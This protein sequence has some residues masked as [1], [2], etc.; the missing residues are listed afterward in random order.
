MPNTSKEETVESSVTQRRTQSRRRTR[1]E[2]Q[3][4]PMTYTTVEDLPDNPDVRLLFEGLLWF[5]YH[6]YDECEVAIH[7]HTQTGLHIKRHRLIV[8]VWKDPGCT[9][10][11]SHCPDVYQIGNPKNIAGIQIDVNRPKYPGVHVYQKDEHGTWADHDWR[12]VIDFEQDPLYRTGITLNADRVNPGVW[13]NHGYFYTLARTTRDFQLRPFSNDDCASGGD[14]CGDP[15]RVAFLVGGNIY[16]DNGGDVTLTIRYRYPQKPTVISLPKVAGKSQ[17]DILNM[18]YKNNKPCVPSDYG[19]NEN[20]FRLYNDTFR[21]P[22]GRSYYFLY[23]YGP[24]E[25]YPKD[26]L[27]GFRTEPYHTQ[28]VIDSS[29]D[30]PCGPVGAGRGGG[31]R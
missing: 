13:I 9:Q 22:A 11:T 19:E 1:A 17:I 21:K 2:E 10:G 18:C 4:K 12:W 14:P 20:D 6:G 30:V 28:K 7:N 24:R 26:D 15:R 27:F 23:P 25:K 16:L 3:S 8:Q 5:M 31:G 29:N